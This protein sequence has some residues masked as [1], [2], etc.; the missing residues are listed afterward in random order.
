MEIGEDPLIF[1]LRL[2]PEQG[3]DMDAIL[4]D[5]DIDQQLVMPAQPALMDQVEQPIAID[6]NR[7]GP[8][9]RF[10]V[11]AAVGPRKH[12]GDHL[13]GDRSRPFQ[14]GTPHLMPD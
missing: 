9:V 4:P 2:D 12:V 14:T 11:V 3:R 6:R 10:D 5:R 7:S 8:S 13:F 1:R